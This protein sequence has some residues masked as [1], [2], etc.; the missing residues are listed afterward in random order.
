VK[1]R[2]LLIL[3]LIVISVGISS[4]VRSVN[5]L[6]LTINVN[7]EKIDGMVLQDTADNDKNVFKP[8]FE[9]ETAFE[10][11][12]ADLGS[13]VTLSFINKLPDKITIQEY[14]LNANGETLYTDIEVK[15]VPFTQEQ[16]KYF[17]TIEKSI[18]AGLNSGL[19]TTDLRGYKVLAFFGNDKKTIIFVIETDF[20]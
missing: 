1:R 12:H 9:K 10:V 7:D 5:D 15:D 20:E 16:S 6:E 3:S 19:H 17:F 18:I 4:C 11:K 2:L 13:I 14:L 8:A